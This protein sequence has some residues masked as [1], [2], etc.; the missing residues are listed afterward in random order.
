MAFK[1]ELRKLIQ[2]IDSDN[3]EDLPCM[4]TR[5]REVA[6][7]M[8]PQYL[9]VL[10]AGHSPRDIDRE[11]VTHALEPDCDKWLSECWPLEDLERRRIARIAFP[12]HLKS[13]TLVRKF[14]GYLDSVPSF[15]S[16]DLTEGEIL[17][18][19]MNSYVGASLK[20]RL[21]YSD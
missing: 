14:V 19:S 17:R 2:Q 10:L 21:I 6:Q 15:R 13:H 8:T 16:I 12:R 20:T 4:V 7:D 11:A 9:R 3:P 1:D 5:L 18:T